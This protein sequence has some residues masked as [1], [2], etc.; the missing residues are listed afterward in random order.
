MAYWRF[1][2]VNIGATKSMPF[3]TLL[4]STALLGAPASTFESPRGVITYK[5]SHLADD[6]KLTDGVRELSAAELQQ[7]RQDGL[8]AGAFIAKYVAA[9][10]RKADLLANL[11]LA[12][13]A[14]LELNSEFKETPGQVEAIV[15]AAFGQY[16]VERMPVRWVMQSDAQ[17]TEFALLGAKPFS[18][19]FPLAAVRYRI[20]D[21]V[22]DFIGALY[23]ALAHFRAGA[24]VTP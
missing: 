21:G 10:Q 20:E 23:E 9:D 17:G 18:K 7:L 16:C 11:D 15:G 2:S 13:T 14:W 4:L 12:F 8:K 3:A 5:E 19:S 22:T 6:A 24:A 1:H